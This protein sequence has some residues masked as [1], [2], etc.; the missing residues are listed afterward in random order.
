MTEE[1]Q[2]QDMPERLPDRAGDYFVVV[3]LCGGWAV[4]TEMARHIEAQLDRRRVP[5]WITF[6]ALWGARVRVRSATLLT[7][8][9]ATPEQRAANRALQRRLEEE[10]DEKDGRWGR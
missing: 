4:S 10:E 1:R 6:V 2:E 7:L 5:E 9:Q 8:E 3:G